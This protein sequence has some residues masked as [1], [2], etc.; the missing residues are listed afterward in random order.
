MRQRIVI[1]L[2]LSIFINIHPIK[3]KARAAAKNDL[4]AAVVNPK[5]DG[6]IATV[7]ESD[8]EIATVVE[9]G[10]RLAMQMELDERDVAVEQV[11]V[12]A[13]AEADAGAA[14]VVVADADA[15]A[16]AARS[17]AV[18]ALV[19]C[20]KKCCCQS[21]CGCGNCGG[22]C[23]GGGC[24][25]GGGGGG[26]RKKREFAELLEERSLREKRS[27]RSSR[28]R[29]TNDVLTNKTAKVPIDMINFWIVAAKNG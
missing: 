19:L 1:S 10:V 7:A 21:C 28:R 20:C 9:D 12:V 6:E 25:G 15:D 24:G 8:G 3:A 11:A 14:V 18:A 17:H 4:I 16:V 22:D 26:G 5:I 23:G 2:F 13:D 27:P 29:V